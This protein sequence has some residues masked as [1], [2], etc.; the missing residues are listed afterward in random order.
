MKS[1]V[2]LYW[3]ISGADCTFLI[4][5][6]RLHFPAVSPWRGAELFFEYPRQVRLI[7]KA[8]GRCYLSQ[9]QARNQQLTGAGKATFQHIFIG[10]LA[11][12]ALKLREK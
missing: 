8:A 6:L 12:V 2:S 7:V 1:S 11:V 10:T 4:E 5:Y 9:R 3:T